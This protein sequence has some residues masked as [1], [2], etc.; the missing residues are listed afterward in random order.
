M[1]T[2]AVLDHTGDTKTIWN[3]D[4]ADEVAAARATFDSLKG[5]GYIAYRVTD[6]G[7]AGSVMA[8]F[9]PLAESVIMRPPVVGG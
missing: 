5:R 1:G 8:E 3:K 4:N 2:M 6:G 7:K 9:D